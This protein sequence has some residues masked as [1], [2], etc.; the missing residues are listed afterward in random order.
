MLTFNPGL[1]L[2]TLVTFVLAVVILWKYAFGPLQGVI[3]ERRAQIRE[4]LETAEAT[5]EEAARLLE[6]YKVT[7]ASVRTEAEEILARSREAG[8]ATRSEIVGEARAEAERTVAKAQQQIER[9][10]RAALKEIKE[11]IA[12]LTM[13]ATEKVIGKSLTDADQRRLL[14]EALRDLN[15][16]DLEVGNPE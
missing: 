1:M 14:D 5:R 16:D 13:L 8:D 12:D 2:W 9:D 15:L 3:D 10:M 11:Q 7:L 4:S 6:E